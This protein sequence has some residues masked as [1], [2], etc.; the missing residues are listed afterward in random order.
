M[1]GR[2]RV[3]LRREQPG[4][5]VA[6]EEAGEDGGGLG[7]ELVRGLELAVA[8]RGVLR[9]SGDVLGVE[10]HER[11]LHHPLRHGTTTARTTL[12]TTTRPRTRSPPCLA[13]PPLSRFPT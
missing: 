8:R 6:R 2:G 1:L 13:A 3:E 12:F 10:G 11:R 4:L 9:L 5:D 7:L